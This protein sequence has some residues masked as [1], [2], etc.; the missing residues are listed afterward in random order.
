MMIVTVH[1]SKYFAAELFICLVVLRLYFHYH[2][3]VT[4][5]EKDV[6]YWRQRQYCVAG[7]EG[8]VVTNLYIR[9]FNNGK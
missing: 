8:S 5:N 7:K 3:F 4:N 1:L 6:T 2:Q 9:S